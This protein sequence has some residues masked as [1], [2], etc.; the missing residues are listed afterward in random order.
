MR[1]SSTGGLLAG[2]EPVHPAPASAGGWT[3]APPLS[4]GDS[5]SD[6]VSDG[7]ATPAGTS[8]KGGLKGGQHAMSSAAQHAAPKPL[9]WTVAW[10][11]PNPAS[12]AELNSEVEW[13][14]DAHGF[15]AITMGTFLRIVTGGEECA[16]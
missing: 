6:D 10:D 1:A 4:E 7:G 13:P 16:Y 15:Q 9:K 14:R 2:K 12:P 11:A 3:M 5:K 8:G